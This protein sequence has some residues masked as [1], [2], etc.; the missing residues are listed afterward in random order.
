LVLGAEMGAGGASVEDGLQWDTA[1]GKSERARTQVAHFSAVLG[2]AIGSFVC[3][4]QPRTEGVGN[5]AD[6]VR[7]LTRG[8]FRLWVTG[9]LFQAKMICRRQKKWEKETVRIA[10]CDQEI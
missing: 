7:P 1:E 6:R 10:F 9:A 3:G 8:R 4:A 2:T 5:D